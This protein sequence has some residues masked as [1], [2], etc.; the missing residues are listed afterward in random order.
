MLARWLNPHVELTPQDRPFLVVPP[1]GEWML[2]IVSCGALGPWISEQLSDCSLYVAPRVAL[3][4]PATCPWRKV[5]GV[6]DGVS[7]F[8]ISHDTL[9][10]VS[11]RDAP[12][13]QVLAVPFAVPD[14]SRARVVVPAGE[15]VV[16]AVRVVGD[17]LLV[18]DLDGGVHRVRHAPLSGGEPADRPLPVEG[19][20]WELTTHPERPQAILPRDHPLLLRKTP[21]LRRVCGATGGL[22]GLRVPFVRVS[23]HRSVDRPD[24]SVDPAAPPFGSRIPSTGRCWRKCR[25]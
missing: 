19:A 23:I 18:R 21:S 20:I 5:A 8:V 22:A 3:A 24:L 9:F 17:R 4:D 2:A 15:R 14:L 25:S 7:A 10:L 6:A 12:R 1:R 11:H 16:E 13:S